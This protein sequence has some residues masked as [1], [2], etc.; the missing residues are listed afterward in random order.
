MLRRIC[1]F[2]LLVLLIGSAL[3][4]ATADAKRRPHKPKPSVRVVNSNVRV[5]IP[6]TDAITGYFQASQDADVKCRYPERPLASGIINAPRYLASQSF[7]TSVVGGYA[8]GAP[9]TVIMKL[10]VLCAKNT[11]VGGGRVPTKTIPGLGTGSLG[12]QPTGRA[13]GTATCPRGQVATGS[14]LSP[15]YAPGYGSF[16][17]IPFGA[18]GWRVAIDSV[19]A[20]LTATNTEAGYVDY[21]CV[22][23]R[24]V[25]KKQLKKTLSSAGTASGIVKCTGGRRPLGWGVELSTYTST[26]GVRDGAWATPMVQRAQFAGNNMLF[27]FATPPGADNSSAGGTPVVAHVL[28]G[29]IA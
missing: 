26:Y 16:S 17:S 21:S 29:V 25:Q 19:P 14:P 12:G 3:F 2:S 22:K 11:K 10:Q 23:A 15:E 7:G 1:T 5:T 4:A 13:T 8:T 9:G 28:C 27:K 24:R 18:R 20:Q 6:E